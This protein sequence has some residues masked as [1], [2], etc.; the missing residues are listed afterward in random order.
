MNQFLLLLAATASCAYAVCLRKERVNLQAELRQAV[1]SAEEERAGLVVMVEAIHDA[2]SIQD[3]ELKVI[4]QNRAHQ[5]LMGNHVGEPCYQAYRNEPAPCPGCHLVET[6]HDGLPRKVEFKKRI[7]DDTRFFEILGSPLKDGSGRVTAGI[8]VIRDISDRKLVEHIAAEQAALLQHLID[9]I[10]NP[11]YYQDDGGRFIWCN[12]AFAQWVC[13]PRERLIGRKL[14]EVVPLSVSNPL[15]VS[16]REG[17]SVSVSEISVTR[18]DGEVR[19]VLFCRSYYRDQVTGRGGMAGVIIDITQRKRAEEE[20]RALNAALSQQTAELQ[21][22]NRELQGFS[23]AISHDLRTPLT[24]I[25]SYAQMLLDYRDR[26]DINGV[27]YLKSVNDGC[28]QVEALL[29]ALMNLSRVTD[30]EILWGTV[31]ISKIA[32]EKVRDLRQ[33][34]PGRKVEIR[35]APSLRATG[36]FQLLGIVMENLIQNAWKYTSKVD[37]PVIEI[38]SATSADGET[39]FYVKD[40]GTGFDAVRTDDLF[41]PFRRL[42][43]SQEYPGTGL[44]LATVRRIISR[45]NGRIWGEGQT[46]CGATFYFTLPS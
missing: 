34:D 46:G 22:V 3:P 2:I 38:G 26:L 44:G 17:E 5:E 6:F 7:G 12:S 1:S 31:D 37:D 15:D 23:H 19:D 41:K 45:H 42:H 28:V 20:I 8:E 11:V 18:E 29:N 10:P 4:Y 16:R 39:V 30:M 27:F 36:D 40:N 14:S 24:R 43:S 21:Q 32:S 13:R 25:Y 9:T 33:T 35:I